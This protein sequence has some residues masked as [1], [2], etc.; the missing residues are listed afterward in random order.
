MT[1]IAAC[2]SLLALLML[3][4]LSLAEAAEEGTTAA[5]KQELPPALNFEMKKLGKDKPVNLA[6]EYAGKVVLLVN[7]ASRCGNTPQYEQL[8]ALHE[9]YAEKGLA[10]VGVPC[11]Q[12]GR[13]EPGTALE[14]IEFCTTNYGVEFDLLEKTNVKQGEPDQCPLYAY[15]TSKKTNPE[16]AGE[17]PWNFE[18]FLISRDGKVV[19]RFNHRTKPDAKEVVE[20]IEAQLDKPAPEKESGAS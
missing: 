11:N 13:Q 8:Q 17:I 12:F 3:A 2:C 15:L 20:A 6:K 10:V 4:P 9:E 19:G 18:K 1:R 5:E 7:V 16:F 14:I